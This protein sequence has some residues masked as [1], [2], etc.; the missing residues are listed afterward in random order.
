MHGPG[1]LTK[2]KFNLESARLPLQP[3]FS[4]LRTPVPIWP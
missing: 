3:S 2:A 1:P 4:S